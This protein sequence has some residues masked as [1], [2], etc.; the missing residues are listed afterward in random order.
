MDE[1]RLAQ[2]PPCRRVVRLQQQSRA[3][4]ESA[5]PE[6]PCGIAGPLVLPQLTAEA[7]RHPAGS[8]QSQR[9]ETCGAPGRLDLSELSFIDARGAAMLVTAARRRPAPAPLMLVRPPAVLRRMLSL[10]YPTESV[11]VVFEEREA[12]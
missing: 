10:L 6:Q 1:D 9:E 4:D 3:E 2:D 11:M 5:C 7:V 12:S 8:E